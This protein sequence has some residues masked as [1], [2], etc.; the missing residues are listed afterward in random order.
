MKQAEI[1]NCP[2]SILTEEQR[3]HYVDHGYL[4]FPELID[5]GLLATLRVALADV[6]DQSRDMTRSSN[7]FD[8]EQGHC[9]QSPKLRRATYLDDRDA[10]FWQLCSESIVPD[11]AADIMGPNVRFRDMMMNFKW[12]G[13]G[14]EVKWHQDA[15]FYPHTNLGTCQF[16]VYLEDVTM[17]QGPLQVIPDSH[18]GPVYAHYDKEGAWTGAIPPD[19][20]ADLDLDAA[21]PLTGPAGT[22]TVHHCLIVHGSS[23][24]ISNCGRPAFVLSYSAA[25]AIPYTAAPYPSSHYGTLV[26]GIEPGVAHHEEMVM[27]LPPDWSDGYTSIFSHQE[28]APG[29]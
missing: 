20:L 27:P 12:S 3:Q 29:D 14:A 7:S 10:V 6:I 19:K 17:D 21:V 11:I 8:L 18:K 9:K 28:E 13:G 2:P 23:R 24:N 15:P 5:N 25:D 26:R 16:L 1:D 4:V 22:V